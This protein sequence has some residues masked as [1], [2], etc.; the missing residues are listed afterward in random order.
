MRLVKH[1]KGLP[2][3]APC[4]SGSKRHLDNALNYM[5]YVLICPEAVRQ[6]DKM[7]F[8]DLFHLN[9]SILFHSILFHAILWV[10]KQ[11]Q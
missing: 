4:L 2:R 6:S 10:G 3:D 5:L 11:K 7:I 8:E 9:D 1:W